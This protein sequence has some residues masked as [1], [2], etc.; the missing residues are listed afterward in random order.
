MN[1]SRLGL[2]L[3]WL[4]GTAFVVAAGLAA[5][6]SRR[7]DP[8][9]H[10]SREQIV[11]WIRQLDADQYE[12]RSEAAARLAQCKAQPELAPLLMEE[13]HRVMVA[14]DTSFE[15]RR[16]LERLWVGQPRAARPQSQTISPDEIDRLVQQLEDD[17]FGTRLSASRRLEWLLE[18]PGLVY[19]ILA[20]LKQRLNQ[21]GLS[22]DARRWLEPVY[23][24]ARAAWLASDPATWRLPPL[25]DDQLAHALDKLVRSA[26]PQPVSSM[27]GLEVHA[28]GELCDLLA[29]DQE[30]PRIRGAIEARLA[31]G[32][33]TEK[34][35]SRLQELVDLTRPALVAEFWQGRRHLNTQYLWIG[36][37]S[38]GPNQSRSSHFEYVGNEMAYCA[39]GQNLSPGYYP[40][41]V[42]IPHPRDPGAVFHLVDLTTPRQKMIYLGRLG[43][44]DP[45]RA[46]A[47][48]GRLRTE[49][50][51]GSVCLV[52]QP[53]AFRQL[54]RR[55]LDRWL[56]T[57][58][59]LSVEE[60]VMLA[61]L[62]PDEVSRFA[63]EYFLIVDDQP[64]PEDWAAPGPEPASSAT[65]HYVG[66]VFTS[67]QASRHGWI[68][69]LLALEGT[70]AAGPGL[71]K[72]IAARRF[73]PPTPQAPYQLPWIAA[74]AI[75]ARDPWP[76]ADS[77]LADQIDRADLLAIGR[78]A[79]PQF[80]ATAAAILLVRHHQEPR[81]FALKETEDPFLDHIGLPG[82]RYEGP[83]APQS[84]KQWWNQHQAAEQP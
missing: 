47:L 54:S 38:R 79:A 12:L 9:L 45:A 42:A 80:G 58:Q 82:Y 62:D 57:R 81:H 49:A 33:L 20:R 13:I 75:A 78:T 37:P 52:D 27:W 24:K 35:A 25:T 76:S 64:V 74:L 1:R 84:I 51:I 55:T 83:E 10:P 26:S 19:P 41:G 3:A 66:R 71:L 69:E 22:L 18:N 73:L 61:Q 77:W 60:L 39:S 4:G 23:T 5:E 65:A 50:G 14:A 28:F 21:D 44:T 40:V 56:A 70:R 46:S 43:E 8:H 30:V 32:G 7:T 48:L 16:Q 68:C 17:Q 72:A 15:V 34:A 11:Q 53:A 67:G 59:R 6:S 31:Q 2:I 63:S 36:V 29:R